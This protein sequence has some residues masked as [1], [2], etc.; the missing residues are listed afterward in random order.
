MQTIP[1]TLLKQPPPKVYQIG[2]R[3]VLGVF[4]EGILPVTG[5]P[6]AL[7]ADP[8]VYFPQQIDPLGAGLAP[9]LGYPISV[10]DDGTIALPLIKE[11]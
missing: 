5:G 6:A 9:A 4:I 8:P 10:G 3:D 11:L 1:L 2:P 7:R